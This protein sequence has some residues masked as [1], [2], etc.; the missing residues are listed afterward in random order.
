MQALDLE[1]FLPPIEDK[2]LNQYKILAKLKEYS[3]QLHTNKLY[4]SF[5]QLNLINNFMDSFLAKY[6]NVTISTS[7]KIKTSSVK[8]SGV[9]I[10]N[11]AEDEDTLEMIE[12]IK[13]AKSLV[14][15]LLDEGIAIYDFVFENISIDAV[16]PQPAYK[17]EGYII[18]PDYKNLQL[19]LIEY[20][21]SLFSSNNKPVQ[22]LKTKLL[23]QVAL[24]N[25]GSSIK[26]TG[27]NLISRFG[28]LVNPAVYVCNTDLDFPFRETLFPIVKSKLLST[29]ANYSSKGY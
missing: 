23:T 13:W 6:R 14:G 27:L 5:A 8:T 15:S 26:E 20:L 3:K 29:L 16:K 18:V 9:N 4:P 2:E 11:A 21:S 24:D 22:S 1:C 17:D 25:T 12:I 7:S 19:L 10:V 28:N